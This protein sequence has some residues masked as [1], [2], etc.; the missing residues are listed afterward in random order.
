[1]TQTQTD[2][3]YRLNLLHA[4]DKACKQG[5]HSGFEILKQGFQW[6]TQKTS[7]FFNNEENKVISL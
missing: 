5:I 1:M 2:S 6:P 4:G 7:V 3:V